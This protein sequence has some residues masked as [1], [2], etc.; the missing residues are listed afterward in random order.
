MVDDQQALKVIEEIIK[1]HDGGNRYAIGIDVAASIRNWGV[2]V[3]R[4]KKKSCVPEI[5]GVFPH[6]LIRANG[7]DHRTNFCR[8]T[9]LVLKTL[10]EWIEKEKIEAAIAV[11]VPFG[12][13]TEHCEFL[14]AFSAKAGMRRVDALPSRADFELRLCDQKIKAR[15]IDEGIKPLSVSADTLGQAAF[16]WAQ[17]RQALQRL[18]GCIDV[19]LPSPRDSKNS[20]HC[21]ETYPAAYIRCCFPN[22]AGYKSPTKVTTRKELIAELIKTYRVQTTVQS[23]AWC[24]RACEQSGSPDA[25]DSLICALCAWDYFQW[26]SGRKGIV[27]STPKE[28]LNRSPNEN[29]ISRIQSEGW[30]LFRYEEFGCETTQA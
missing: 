18:L 29:E 11:D 5:V 28:I 4:I 23:T 8:P 1:H 27:M 15:F 21:F 17:E 9:M 12:W 14:N 24:K 13:P 6:S 3:I 19:G 22:Q 20:V 10:L 7:E 2:S 26:K 25:L 16:K 30:M